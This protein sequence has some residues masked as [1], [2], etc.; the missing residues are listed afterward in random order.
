MMKKGIAAL[1]VC[2]LSGCASL[3]YPYAN[4]SPEKAGVKI[5]I[6]SQDVV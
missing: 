2:A 3:M 6:V 5:M 4:L 1:M